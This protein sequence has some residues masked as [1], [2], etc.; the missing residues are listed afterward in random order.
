M[1]THKCIYVCIHTHNTCSFGMV[2]HSM[3]AY[4]IHRSIA[5]RV[6][7]FTALFDRDCAVTALRA[8]FRSSRHPISA[9]STY[10]A[11]FGE[12]DRLYTCI[13]VCMYACMCV[14]V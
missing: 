6:S 5:E 8:S 14:C 3:C 9:M 10:S 2:E 1:H 4:P 13:Y 11:R 7:V 12:S